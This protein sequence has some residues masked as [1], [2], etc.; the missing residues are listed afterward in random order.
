MFLGVFILVYLAGK[1]A[2]VNPLATLV[3]MTK[4]IAAG[5]FD[6]SFRFP[7]HD[8]IGQ[9][10]ESVHWMAQQLRRNFEQIEAQFK[11]IQRVLTELKQ[12]EK[13]LRESES[14]SAH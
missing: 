14:V 7:Q 9:L 10:A 8:E 11:V 5:D 4:A 6:Q 3:N 2:I 13:A 12:A 1:R